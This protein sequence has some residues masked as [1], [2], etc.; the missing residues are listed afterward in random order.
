[1]GLSSMQCS[2]AAALTTSSLRPASPPVHPTLLPSQSTHMG[3]ITTADSHAHATQPYDWKHF[4]WRLLLP[5]RAQ[6]LSSLI[7]A[8][9][10]WLALYCTPPDH[11][12]RAMWHYASAVSQRE[13]DPLVHCGSRGIEGS[14]PVVQKPNH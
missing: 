10:A 12:V 5:H 7:D 8:V 9:W 13:Y 4:K 2:F 11:F 14:A 1:M 3:L 6:Q